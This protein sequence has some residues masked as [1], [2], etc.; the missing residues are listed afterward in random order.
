MKNEIQQKYC[1]TVKLLMF[2]LL[3]FVCA[4]VA[5]A[6]GRKFGLF[7]GINEY[8][9]P[10]SP[11]R[12][13]VNDAE[14]MQAAMLAK[15]GFKKADTTILTDTQATRDGI[16]G[17]IKMYEQMAGE[18]DLF[19]FHYSGHGTL[20]PDANSEEQ[21]ETELQYVEI[22]YGPGA[23][24][25]IFP[26]AKYDSAI[27]PID[28]AEATSGKPWQNLILDDELYQMFAAFTKKGAQVVFISDSCHSGSVAR[29]EKTL[30]KVRFTPLHKAFDAKSFADL[31]LK[32]PAAATAKPTAA[33]TQLNGMYL[34]MTDSK[35]D[36]FSLDAGEDGIPMGL[37]T[38][39]LLKTLNARGAASLT[40]KK[41]I[42][43]VSPKVSKTAL[44]LNN[45]QNPQLDSRFGNADKLI[46][47]VP[48]IKPPGA[49][50]SK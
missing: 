26:R 47:S 8:A 39:T 12:G 17:K 13:C 32:K 16:I 30:T 1:I 50:K 5:E 38:S 27:V 41:L 31:N 3:V 33:Q 44:S 15:Y 43:S 4:A 14:K 37:F 48:K 10:V 42:E 24:E 11:L 9:E 40:Y 46:F 49:K 36:E 34:T 45:N 35:D 29:A 25:V 22:A 20:F 28:V 18:D 6:K 7:V 19:V 21:D 2:A 23:S